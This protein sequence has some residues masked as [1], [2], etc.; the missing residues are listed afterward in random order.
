MA[1]L[2]AIEHEDLFRFYL[3]GLTEKI[4][5]MGLLFPFFCKAR[6]A[7]AGIRGSS[8]TPALQDLESYRRQASGLSGKDYVC[9]IN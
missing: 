5:C 4:D 2:S 1:E 8:K 7:E 6:L 3:Y 9:Q